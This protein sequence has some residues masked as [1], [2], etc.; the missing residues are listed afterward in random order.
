MGPHSSVE[1]V[2]DR[3]TDIKGQHL[4]GCVWSED[5]ERALV[6]SGS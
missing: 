1:G 2:V 3:M 4:R 6:A 5:I